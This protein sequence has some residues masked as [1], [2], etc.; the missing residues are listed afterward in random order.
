M[1]YKKVLK[2]VLFKFDPEDM[3]NLFVS[4]GEFLGKN[5]LLKNIVGVF[6]KY[7]GKD[8]SK[9]VDGITYKTPL[10]LSAGFDYNGRLLNILPEVS[11]GG[12]EVGSVTAKPCAGNEKPRLMRLPKSQ[13][14]VVFKGLR[15]D[16]VEA[17]IKRLK[18]YKK[19][20]GFVVG[21]S[22]ARTNDKKTC[23]EEEGIA[24]YFYSF[25]RLNEE[26]VGDYYAINI[27]CPNAFGG[28]SF[29]E[30]ERLSALLSRLSSVQCHKPVYVKMPINLEW[31]EFDS[32][33]KVLE[34]FE[35]IKGVII[36][37]VN[38][39]Y[40]SLDFREEAPKEY[41]GGLSGKPCFETSNRLIK[42]TKEAYGKRFT[43]IGCGGIMS[44]ENMIEKF[45]AG[46]DLVALI[47]GM[48]YNGP[49]FI[50]ELSYHYSK[51]I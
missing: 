29:A 26:N 33:L 2:P 6:Y 42:Q 47:T 20:D 43:I 39:D 27:S 8:I 51:N 38:K 50:K 22:I 10:I 37:N 1:F 28:E 44:P 18:N 21:I 34:K 48:I 46:S 30:P 15:N 25:K 9:T 11:F 23:S 12:V 49:G 45:K 16:G 7:K 14:L 40:N 35:M 41:K 24:D 13:S 36:G 4:I 5:R 17:V 32:L 3:H 19:K 31:S